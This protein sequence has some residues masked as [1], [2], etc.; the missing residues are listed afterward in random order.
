MKISFVILFDFFSILQCISPNSPSKTES[1]FPDFLDLAQIQNTVSG[2]VG[3][4]GELFGG[5][6]VDFAVFSVHF[7]DGSSS[8]WS[9]AV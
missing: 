6:G 9:T 8:A 5:V 7:P 3:F 1:L 2:S 4:G